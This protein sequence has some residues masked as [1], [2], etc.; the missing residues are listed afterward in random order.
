MGA[1][2]VPNFGKKLGVVFAWT[3]LLSLV[4][5]TAGCSQRHENAQVAADVQDKIRGD[6]R[7]QM[8]RVQVIAT[9]GVVTLSGYVVSNQQR[10]STVED[11][12]Q[13]QG[14]KTVIDNLKVVNSKIVDSAVNDSTVHN[15]PNNNSSPQ[16]PAVATQK[17]SPAIISLD[18]PIHRTR[19]PASDDVDPDSTQSRT[20]RRPAT[21]PMASSAPVR[22]NSSAS[23]PFSS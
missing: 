18:P 15:S 2:L 5:A 4:L 21:S 12:A 9:G 3:G 16:R 10:A 20:S 7:M 6:Q 1:T 19:V 22:T 23:Q 8:A 11:A 14:V 17:P 13:V